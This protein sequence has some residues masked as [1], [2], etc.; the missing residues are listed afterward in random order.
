M[1]EAEHSN[2]L[3]YINQCLSFWLSKRNFRGSYSGDGEN[4]CLLECGVLSGNCSLVLQSN[5]Q[6][7][8]V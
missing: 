6:G 1:Q 2:V 7:R 8:S 4:N 3:F 5:L